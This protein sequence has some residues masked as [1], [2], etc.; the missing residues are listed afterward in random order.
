MGGIT[1]RTQRR[2]SGTCP[3]SARS[4]PGSRRS[5]RLID[6]I[7]SRGGRVS[8]RELMRGPAKYRNSHE[9]QAAIDLLVEQ[10]S[11]RY[12][13]VREAEPWSSC[14][15]QSACTPATATL[16]PLKHP[17][18]PKLSL[19]RVDAI[20]FPPIGKDSNHAL[21]LTRQ[22]RHQ[23][24]PLRRC[25]R[26]MRRSNRRQQAAKKRVDPQKQRKDLGFRRSSHL[27]SL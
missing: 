7:R 1:T 6:R 3:G 19:A 20:R 14:S 2:R 13:R 10:A 17:R 12:A 24:H 27:I 23:A 4:S 15:I 8:K 5:C 25:R 22:E 26:N 18:T 21:H 16:W 9:A 11:E